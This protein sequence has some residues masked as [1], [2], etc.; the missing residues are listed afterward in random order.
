MEPDEILNR[1][2]LVSLRGYARDEV[3]AFKREVAG[4]VN[5]LRARWQQTASELRAARDGYDQVRGEL[6]ELK[7]ELSDTRA[8]LRAAHEQSDQAAAVPP[9]DRGAG[10]RLVAQE[11][12]RILM[13][14]EQ[15]ADEMHERAIRDAAEI[16]ADARMSADR[17]FGE[18][19]A[20]RRAA[21]EELDNIRE[22]RG[23]IA[24]QME[25]I[26]RRLAETVARLRVPVESPGGRPGGRA[27]SGS[28]DP[29][30]LRERQIAER[31][32][33]ERSAGTRPAAPAERQVSEQQVSERERP[34]EPA[35]R[36]RPVELVARQSQVEPVARERPVEPVARQSQVEPVARER[37]VEPAA[38]QRPGGPLRR[39][40]TGQDR[41]SRPGEPAIGRTGAQARA[42]GARDA[43]ETA[44]FNRTA[45]AEAAAAEQAAANRRMATDRAAAENATG[46][47]AVTKLEV[48][49]QSVTEGPTS[50]DAVASKA[51]A[52]AAGSQDAAVKMALPKNPSHQAAA[53][54]TAAP[55]DVAPSNDLDEAA[56]PPDA[57]YGASV[58][59]R[60]KEA[61]GP[62]QQA[63]VQLSPRESPALAGVNS[64]LSE[65]LEEIRRSRESEK[66]SDNPPTATPTLTPTP[67]TPVEAGRSMLE[68]RREALD[69][70]PLQTARRLK[71][72]LQEDHNDLLDR[73]RTQRGKGVLEEHLAP[74]PEQFGRFQIGLS[75]NLSAAFAHGREAGGA[76]SAS[77][78]SK[79]VS[80]LVARQVV[81]PLRSEV[82]KAIQAGID[83]QESASGIAERAS[84]VFRVWKGV[85][86]EML[87]EGMVYAAF[88][89]GLVDAWSARTN[90]RKLW[91][92][93]GEGGECPSEVC[94]KNVAAG[95]LPLRA[96]FP[97]GHLTPPAH[98]GCTCTLSTATD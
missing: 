17:T 61:Q 34:V 33:M 62:G 24:G 36:E 19:D 20:G 48:P 42:S 2:F 58:P 77:D 71:R 30:M 97:S 6:E 67:T 44:A 72:L 13:A 22:A 92:P 59:A 18:I 11:T 93:S 9:D 84:D 98:G 31:R 4:E 12:E 66:T 88:N 38:R 46:A 15:V 43:A 29:Q 78:S 52:P 32:G 76:A 25:D 39:E 27:R 56:A 45:A 74:L 3:E 91:V 16:V 21:E 85:R 95:A 47:A 63:A 23:M 40:R 96:A 86:T 28:V 5:E 49:Q 14:A 69:E 10:Y 90:A 83:A 82:S 26:G 7:R 94:R 79:A 54:E 51:S 8:Q 1:E 41:A 87:G 89:Q 65:L 73:V 75:D 81:N 80:N 64:S 53:D 50:N 37:P 55:P 60:A 70:L 68:R 57:S 35:A